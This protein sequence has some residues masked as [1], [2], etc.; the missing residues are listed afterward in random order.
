[1]KSHIFVLKITIKYRLIKAF[2]IFTGSLK[3]NGLFQILIIKS[4]RIFKFYK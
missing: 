3:S 4:I 2:K 1:M